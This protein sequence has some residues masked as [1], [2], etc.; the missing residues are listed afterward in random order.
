MWADVGADECVPGPS[1]R[2]PW[3]QDEP[4]KDKIGHGS[5]RSLEGES[6]GEPEVGW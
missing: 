1:S 3:G 6:L 2:Q 4:R 5:R